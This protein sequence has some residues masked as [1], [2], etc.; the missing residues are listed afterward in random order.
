MTVEL[1][2]ADIIALV[3]ALKNYRDDIL[4][5]SEDTDTIVMD[6]VHVD[7]LINKLQRA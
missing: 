6:T 7:E 3:Q 5:G 1:T 4:S 2:E